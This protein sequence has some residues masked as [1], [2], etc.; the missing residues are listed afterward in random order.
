MHQHQLPEPSPC[1]FERLLRI[2]HPQIDD[3][4][5]CSL[6]I[7]ILRCQLAKCPTAKIRLRIFQPT[8]Q[9]EM[10]KSLIARKGRGTARVERSVTSNTVDMKC[11]CLGGA[12]P[13]TSQDLYVIRAIDGVNDTTAG[14]CGSTSKP[15][16]YARNCYALDRFVHIRFISDEQYLCG[17]AMGS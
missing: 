11:C 17:S 6:I 9:W 12:K 10:A 14:C 13:R 2:R 15:F 7:I 16:L 5:D 8:V 1:L 4:Q 3:Y